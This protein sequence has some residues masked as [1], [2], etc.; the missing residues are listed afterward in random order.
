MCIRDS[1]VAEKKLLPRKKL[2]EKVVFHDSCYLGRYNGV[3]DE[4]RTVLAAIGVQLAE[5][6][7]NRSN[8]LC[9]GAGGGRIWMAEPPGLTRRPSELRIDEALEVGDLDYFVVA[10]PKDVSMYE[11]AI[12]TSGH[13]GKIE[14]RELS[15]LV[16]EALAP[17]ER[18]SDTTTSE[19]GAHE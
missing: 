9:C 6:P 5:M 1:L 18:I 17:P 4:P 7:R 8:S 10:C 2:E 12:K 3:Y 14:L 16:W 13:E 11:D 15:E 19:E